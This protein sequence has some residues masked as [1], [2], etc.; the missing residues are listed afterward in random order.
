[1]ASA[2]S[3]SHAAAAAFLDQESAA[4]TAGISADASGSV[5]ASGPLPPPDAW[6]RTVSDLLSSSTDLPGGT[7]GIKLHAKAANLP[8]STADSSAASSGSAV[9]NVLL[10]VKNSGDD[11]DGD[12][13]RVAADD[14]EEGERDFTS[15]AVFSSSSSVPAIRTAIVSI[16]IGACLSSASSTASGLTGPLDA[17]VAR[18]TAVNASQSASGSTSSNASAAATSEP[19]VTWRPLT[20]TSD[21]ADA[22]IPIV[23][24][25]R[26]VAELAQQQEEGAEEDD[27]KQPNPSSFALDLSSDVDEVSLSLASAAAELR[28]ARTASSA[29]IAQLLARVTAG[30]EAVG[31]LT[32]LGLGLDAATTAALAGALPFEAPHSAASAS[33][34]GE[35]SHNN[36]HSHDTTCASASSGTVAATLS[37]PDPS[38]VDAGCEMRPWNFPQPSPILD[39]ARKVQAVTATAER[40]N[41]SKPFRPEVGS[42]AY[43]WPALLPPIPQSSKRLRRRDLAADPSWQACLADVTSRIRIWKSIT[44]A[45]ERGIKDR[46]PEGTGTNNSGGGGDGG[47]SS[48]D[49]SAGNSGGGLPAEELDESLVVPA[50]W[51]IPVAG[52]PLPKPLP[53]SSSSSSSKTSSVAAA[54]GKRSSSSSSS[55]ST[56]L[57][58]GSEAHP[59]TGAPLVADAAQ[60]SAAAMQECG[61][62]E[63]M[64]SVCLDGRATEHNP[65]VYCDGCDVGVHCTCY[66]IASVP[67]GDWY[68]DACEVVNHARK[69]L[70]PPV[71]AHHRAALSLALR[72]TLRCC[73]CP[74]TGGAL[75]PTTDGRWAH[76]ICATLTPGCWIT[77]L[78]TMGPIEVRPDPAALASSLAITRPGEVDALVQRSSPSPSSSAASA[79]VLAAAESLLERWR[80]YNDLCDGVSACLDRL[81]AERKR[82]PGNSALA[83]SLIAI[84]NAAAAGKSPFQLF[85]GPSSAPTGAGDDASIVP[86]AAPPPLLPP[87]FADVAHM[88]TSQLKEASVTAN[89]EA[90]SSSSD[91]AP[92]A[93]AANASSAGPPASSPLSTSVPAQAASSESAIAQEVAAESTPAAAAASLVPAAASDVSA[94]RVP[95]AASEDG[96]VQPPAG[97]PSGSAS[98]NSGSIASSNQQQQRQ[99]VTSALASVAA[100]AAL[101]PSSSSPPPASCVICHLPGGRLR[102]CCG[103]DVTSTSTAGG[104]GRNSNSSGST[105]TTIGL[106]R[107]EAYFHPL[108][109]WYAGCFLRLTVPGSRADRHAYGQS[110]SAAAAASAPSAATPSAF[111]ARNTSATASAV[112]GVAA[113]TAGL[114]VTKDAATG[115]YQ[116]A[117]AS[118]G[119]S[120]GGKGLLGS[121][122]RKSSIS[123]SGSGASSSTTG[124]A[125]ATR[126]LA[127]ATAVT[128]AIAAAEAEEDA[129]AGLSTI[130]GALYQGGGVGLRFRLFCETHS[131]AFVLHP[132]PSSSATSSS[133]STKTTVTRHAA[134]AAEAKPS[135]PITVLLPA[136]AALLHPHPAPAPLSRSVAAQRALRCKYRVAARPDLQ[137]ALP[138]RPF[139]LSGVAAAGGSIPGAAASSYGATSAPP[140]GANSSLLSNLAEQD[141]D[142]GGA[143]SASSAS[144]GGLLQQRTQK[145]EQRRKQRLLANGG[146]ASSGSSSAGGTTAGG[147]RSAASSGSANANRTGRTGAKPAVTLTSQPKPAPAPAPAPPPAPAPIPILYP[148]KPLPAAWT[149]MRHMAMPLLTSQEAA[150]DRYSGPYICAIC[151]DPPVDQTAP[152]APPPP[153]APAPSAAPP[154]STTSTVSVE[155]AAAVASTGATATAST[156]AAAA[157]T[158]SAHNATAG[159]GSTPSTSSVPQRRP[160]DMLVCAKCRVAAHRTCYGLKPPGA[161]GLT[162]AD[163]NTMPLPNNPGQRAF[164]CERCH[165]LTQVLEAEARGGPAGAIERGLRLA[166]SRVKIG[167]RELFEPICAICSR[168]GGVLRMTHNGCGWAHLACVL[169][170][171][172]GAFVRPAAMVGPNISGVDRARFRGPRCVLCSSPH[173]AVMGCEACSAMFHP[174]C[175]AQAKCFWGYRPAAD[176]AAEAYAYCKAHAPP[177]YIFDAAAQRWAIDPDYVDPEGEEEEEEQEEDEAKENGD[178]DATDSDDELATR[179]RRSARRRQEQKHKG[180]K[181]AGTGNNNNSAT[182]AAAKP[183]PAALAAAILSAPHE[184]I[185]PDAVG[186][187]RL[188]SRLVAAKVLLTSVLGREQLKRDFTSAEQRLFHAER[189]AAGDVTGLLPPAPPSDGL[190]VHVGTLGGQAHMAALAALAEDDDVAAAVAAALL[191][192]HHTNNGSSSN[193]APGSK[194]KRATSSSGASA[195][196][197]ELA[198]LL[199]GTSDLPPSEAVAAFLRI[200]LETSPQALA[201]GSGNLSSPPTAAA[202]AA[203]GIADDDLDGVAAPTSAARN[204]RGSAASAS[205]AAPA[206]A[207][208]APLAYGERSGIKVRLSGRDFPLLAP[209]FASLKPRKKHQRR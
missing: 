26:L 30:G 184:S 83:E 18:A 137:P 136:A 46:P 3:A 92:P 163:L 74:I 56:R 140:A 48:A 50:S 59:T 98:A 37:P 77:R 127:M 73:L 173:G 190:D 10:R 79:G 9:V 176:G 201:A 113:V 146:C 6:A 43:C 75:K 66:G 134:A 108:C 62:G 123:S 189:H 181:S 120:D 13:I 175:A 63:T 101:T 11:E 171:P 60:Q 143:A 33:T 61:L 20:A 135:N 131:P 204:A 54:T 158:S 124:G 118:A 156:A 168:G 172:G 64:C 183:S 202:A 142:V 38:A 133:A 70:K 39:V 34:H 67:E 115:L 71:S 93:S 203:A 32:E 185:P 147:S 166:L 139:G 125:T 186:L 91:G 150:L 95:A 187:A 192:E 102:R 110:A 164:Q 51:T 207:C 121:P 86:P 57:A 191:L 206:P 107:C 188:R 97:T 5:A 174:M 21:S 100:A 52:R 161:G 23:P 194:R 109:A 96:G 167:T 106:R 128:A 31:P 157:P 36:S 179:K 28:E 45:L 69:Q 1:M 2:V 208:A 197:S 7:L 105:T 53:D 25:S 104:S 41:G 152:P 169:M 180:R 55:T 40:S 129:A 130:A 177:G 200:V 44:S 29:R 17:V 15:G 159:V 42:L 153:P 165:A 89:T 178:T 68:C 117:P 14:E 88:L 196:P 49:G 154:A 112:T 193:S 47:G 87:T 90:N 209:L 148:Y 198:S 72:A 132:T 182:A 170:I 119:A 94:A 144:G 195:V 99:P 116:V 82:Q 145:A 65:L 199:D 155:G 19:L 84:A 138:P 114:A 27:D 141:Y 12:L 8:S 22:S 160:S 58:T 103:H 24:P 78:S 205:S 4:F 16:D 111:A 80:L 162:D 35:C 149:G 85:V 81:A 122:A 126:A 151:F 76:L